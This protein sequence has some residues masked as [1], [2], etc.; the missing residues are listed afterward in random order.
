MI[1]ILYL[2]YHRVLKLASL[3]GSQA[4]NFLID[5]PCVTQDLR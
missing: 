1:D 4:I 2:F 3:Q 5:M